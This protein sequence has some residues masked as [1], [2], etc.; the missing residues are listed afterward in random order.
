MVAI[1]LVVTTGEQIEGQVKPVEAAMPW[2]EM[3]T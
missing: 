1:V 2:K 3:F